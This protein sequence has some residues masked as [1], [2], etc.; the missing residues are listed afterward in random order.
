MIQSWTL[1]VRLSHSIKILR[2]I[3]LESRLLTRRSSLSVDGLG[4]CVVQAPKSY[5]A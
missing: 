3:R 5:F 1:S 4:G 2:L